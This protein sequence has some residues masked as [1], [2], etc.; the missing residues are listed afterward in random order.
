[1][2]HGAMVLCFMFLLS[3]GTKHRY[4]RGYIVDHEFAETTTPEFPHPPTHPQPQPQTQP[5]PQQQ[6]KSQPQPQSHT[7]FKTVMGNR[8]A[9]D[10]QKPAAVAGQGVKRKKPIIFVTGPESSGNRYTVQML[11]GA[12][13]CH[14]K[15]GHTQPLDHKKKGREKKWDILDKNVL[16]TIKA[17]QPCAVIHRSFPHNH[18][19]VDLKTMANMAREQGFSPQV[20]VLHRF[21]PAVLDSQ[22]VR[23]HVT[24]NIK[25]RINTKRAYLEIFRDIVDAE[26]PYTIVV[27]ELLKDPK[28]VHWLFD[29]IGLEYDAS[30]VPEFKDKNEKHNKQK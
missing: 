24:N 9:I 25:A 1:M 27:Y 8:Q 26:L 19:F 10:K 18:I 2:K 23:K 5:Q 11:I 21:M 17:S 15:S 29:E 6:T 14:G 12:A 16:K 20:I 28:Y 13:G 22:V 3:N 7:D 30:R 4:R